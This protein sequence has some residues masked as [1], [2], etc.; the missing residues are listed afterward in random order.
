M[1]VIGLDCFLPIS[2]WEGDSGGEKKEGRRG[3]HFPCVIWISA[4]TEMSE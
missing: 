3:G 4:C 2:E 1:L